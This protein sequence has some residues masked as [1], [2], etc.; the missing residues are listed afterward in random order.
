MRNPQRFWQVQ[1]TPFLPR[2]EAQEAA[3]LRGQNVFLTEQLLPEIDNQIS[4]LEEKL[5][6]LQTQLQLI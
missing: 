3:E 4:A 5:G 6:E 1:S 2:E